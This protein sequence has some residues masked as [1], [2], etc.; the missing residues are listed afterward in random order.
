MG[1]GRDIA[2]PY[3]EF[4]DGGEQFVKESVGRI[5]GVGSDIIEHAE[6]FYNS[7][8]FDQRPAVDGEA[9]AI[10]PNMFAEFT[11]LKFIGVTRLPLLGASG[12]A[13]AVDGGKVLK[14][15]LTKGIQWIRQNGK[16]FKNLSDGNNLPKITNPRNIKNP[17]PQTSKALKESPRVAGTATG[18]AIS[19]LVTT[20]LDSATSGVSKPSG[21][22][23]RFSSPEP[24]EYFYPSK[25]SRKRWV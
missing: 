16:N 19:T 1:I 5:E 17:M 25:V 21:E 2:E 10:H 7:F 15:G 3:L 22:K 8:E 11:G 13:K 9:K 6:S 14:E 12:I 23:Q 18:I 20:L 24:S 4:A